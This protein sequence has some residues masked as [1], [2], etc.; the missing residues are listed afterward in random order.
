MNLSK[1]WDEIKDLNPRYLG[2]STGAVLNTLPSGR[3]VVV[4]RGAHPKHIENEFDMNRYLNEIGIT[5]PNASLER[6]GS[7]LPLM[8]TDFEEAA[9][10]PSLTNQSDIATLRQ[11]FVPQAL[12]AN[13]DVLGMGLDNVLMR[14]DGTP[15]Y[16][17]VGG[18]GPYRAQG[19]TKPNFDAEVNELN[20]MQYKPPFTPQIYG[21][22]GRQELQDSYDKYGG[23]MNQAL[24]VLRDA[25]TRNIMQDRIEN[26]TNRIDSL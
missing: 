3:K 18:A 11:D 17:D 12:I 6:D 7:G 4:K 10:P 21:N 15:S 14:P 22:M 2:G 16:V 9:R 24:E 19:A 8:I 1:A 20:T 5:V 25:Q 13:W 26:L 23:A